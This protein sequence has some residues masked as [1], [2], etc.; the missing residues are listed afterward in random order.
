[1]TTPSSSRPRSTLTQLFMPT[2]DYYTKAECDGIFEYAAVKTDKGYN[3][4]M[5]VPTTAKEGDKVGIMFTV[6]GITATSFL[7]PIKSGGSGCVR[8]CKASHS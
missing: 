5:S 3:A 2:S 1:M 6:N 7:V 8:F 4:E